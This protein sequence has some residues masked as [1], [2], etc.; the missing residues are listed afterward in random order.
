MKE[1][2]LTKLETSFNSG[3]MDSLA[4]L[5]SD[6]YTMEEMD[7]ATPP[8]NPRSRKK[9]EL[10]QMVGGAAGKG[11]K[12]EVENLVDGGDRIAYT[13]HCLIPNGRKVTSNV[14]SDVKDGKI[15]KE[16]HVSARDPEK[17]PS[18]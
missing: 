2:D 17:R 5:Y 13:V 16:L 7:D 6:D 15:Y 4:D 10:V 11:V 12:F 8:S 9:A 14:I 1:F 3:D 18:A